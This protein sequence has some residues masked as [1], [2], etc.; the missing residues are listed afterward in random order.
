MLEVILARGPGARRS[1]AHVLVVA[2]LLGCLGC[3]VQIAAVDPKS[4]LSTTRPGRQI[5]YLAM[6][7]AAALVGTVVGYR[8]ALRWARPA[9][10]VTWGLLLV[11]LMPGMD[12]RNG[13]TRWIELGPIHIQPSELAKP[14]LVL[15]F[16]ALAAR[17]KE[18][19]HTFFR[20]FV[21]AMLYIGVTGAL[22]VLEPDHGQTLFLFAIAAT[23]LLIN[24]QPFKH[25]LPLGL[26][27]LP[28]FVFLASEKSGYV[29]ARLEGFFAGSHYQVQQGAYAFARGGFSGEGLGDLRAPLFVPEVHNDFALAAVGEQLGFLGVFGVVVLFLWFFW[30]GLRIAFLA[31]TQT[32]FSVAFGMVF[33]IA[34]QAAVNI[35]VVSDSVPPKGIALPFLSYGGSS[36]IVT[37]LCIG[38]LASV[39]ADAYAPHQLPAQLRLRLRQSRATA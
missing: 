19:L 27:G 9:L 22:V 3:L 23:V 30:H 35:A 12:E 4:P 20:G 26:L 14:T 34:L 24:G 29:R 13:S 37:G 31:K 1:A 8:T 28:A 39:A 16:T 36:I 10:W 2:L 32:G 7:A 11:L 18:I 21:P 6:A 25:F 33:I 38:L 5:A 15:F 17:K